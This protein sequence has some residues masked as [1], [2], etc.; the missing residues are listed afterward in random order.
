MTYNIRYD[1]PED[2]LNAWDN[3]KL[4]L[5]HLIS[6]YKPDV[7]GIQEGLIHQLHYLDAQLT[8]YSRIGLGRDDGLEKGEF[9]AIYY[10]H[11]KLSL[12]KS[13]TFWLS[14][15]PDTVSVGWDASMERI[16]TYGLFKDKSTKKNVWIFNT[17]Y[18][19]IGKLAREKS[20]ELI[21][22]KIR[23]VNT[24]DYPVILMGDFNS[25]PNSQTITILT[26]AF[27]DASE[28]SS[29]GIYGPAGTF[30]GFD[31]NTLAE[32]RI[33]YLFVKNLK[34]TTYRHIDDKMKNSNY[35]SDHLPVLIE[36][37]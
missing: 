23:E 12:I 1:N 29:H 13:S 22:K 32:K 7:L 31:K 3:R 15:R 17:H 28:K 19:H 35:L 5:T 30:T 33:D 24:N 26:N 2:G 25:E 6:Y 14:E 34:V 18:D 4:E 8:E 21:L 27:G 16:C 9:S 37:E 11:N 20:S 10:N 36:L